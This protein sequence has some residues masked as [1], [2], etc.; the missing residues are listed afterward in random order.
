MHYLR[1]IN[2]KTQ[3]IGKNISG[4]AILAMM[5]VIVLD[6]ILRNVFKLT[7]PGSYV[8]IESFLMPL[9]IFPALGYVYMAGVL[10]RLGEFIERRSIKFQ[11]MNRFL[12]LIIDIIVFVLLTYFTFIFFL[13][14]YNDGI[15]IPVATNFVPLWP[16]YFFIPLG[17]FLV[18]LEVLLQFVEEVKRFSLKY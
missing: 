6:V 13:D 15:A 8:I 12:L 18:L 2:N 3:N 11:K 17:Y 7:I 10:P 9:A 5:F 4:L 16:I 1:K 14:G